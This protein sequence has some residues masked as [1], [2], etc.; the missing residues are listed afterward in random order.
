M[1]PTFRVQ[2][3]RWH[4]RLI[5]NLLFIL[6]SLRMDEPLDRVESDTQSG[7]DNLKKKDKALFVHE[8][9]KKFLL[10]FEWWRKAQLHSVSAKSFQG[11][12]RG[13]WQKLPEAIC[14]P[15]AV[16][17]ACHTNASSH[18]RCDI[19]RDA[20]LRRPL[21]K[22]R[23]PRQGGLGDPP[24]VTPAVNVELRFKLRE[25]F[26]DRERTLDR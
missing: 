4:T 2:A 17:S 5:Y 15:C 18:L 1:M 25:G 20:Q 3:H 26:R 9:S 7:M 8:P 14:V 12:A 19:K 16:P 23:K 21:S 10:P 22:A 13:Q 11:D 24:H 6:N